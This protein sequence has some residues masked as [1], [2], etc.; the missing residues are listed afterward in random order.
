MADGGLWPRAHGE[1]RSSARDLHRSYGRGRAVWRPPITFRIS[2]RPAPPRPSR[3]SA[4]RRWSSA[5]CSRSDGR[6]LRTTLHSAHTV[7][8]RP[9]HVGYRAGRVGPRNRDHNRRKAMRTIGALGALALVLGLTLPAMAQSPAASD[10]MQVQMGPG[11]GGPGMGGPGRGGPGMQ[12]ERGRGGW[13]KHA[14]HRHMRRGRSIVFMALRNQKELGLSPQQVSSLQQLGMDAG[15]ASIK[16]RADGQLAK[17]D[18]FAL[19]K[20]EPVDMAKVEAKIQ[21][22]RAAQGRRRRCPHPDQRSG[23][24]AA[25][26]RSAGE[27]QDPSR[28]PVAAPRW[29]RRRWRWHERSAIRSARPV[30]AMPGPRLPIN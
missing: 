17:L 10:A 1:C 23:Q 28:G 13:Q 22:H 5:R 4:T 11:G 9:P 24:G 8:T 12:S 6:S 25:H 19:M 16:R 20:A 7:L 29:R 21:R 18:L 30:V 3:R 27:A 14:G 2:T 15:R 26:A